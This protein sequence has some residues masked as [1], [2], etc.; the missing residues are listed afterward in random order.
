MPNCSAVQ[1]LSLVESVTPSL[2]ISG[3][4]CKP[5]CFQA[6][7]YFEYLPPSLSLSFFSLYLFLFIHRYIHGTYLNPRLL[8]VPKSSPLVLYQVHNLM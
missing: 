5:P 3:L 1:L 4:A 6:C 2:H 8:A 7:C